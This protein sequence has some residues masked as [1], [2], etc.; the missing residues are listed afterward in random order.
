MTNTFCLIDFRR[1]GFHS[2]RDK[3]RQLSRQS[4][5]TTTKSNTSNWNCTSRW[6]H[7]RFVEHR[8]V[9]LHVETIWREQCVTEP[10]SDSFSF[11]DTPIG[12]SDSPWFNATT[13]I[14]VTIQD[15]DN[16]P[17]W[18]QP[19]TMLELSGT[20]VCVGVQRYTGNVYLNEQ[21]VHEPLF[22]VVMPEHCESTGDTMRTT[23]MDSGETWTDGPS[24][25]NIFRSR[26]DQSM[27]NCV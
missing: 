8:D 20:T 21:Q 11:K 6:V 24:V 15:I 9:G 13:T 4:L 5:S 10:W 12:S 1:R 27:I 16:R 7:R 17:P 23:S 25:V 26:V 14:N 18:F 3:I 2:R 22:K 19:C